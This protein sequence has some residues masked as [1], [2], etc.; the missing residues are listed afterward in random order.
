MLESPPMTE[1]EH[2][3]SLFTDQT[4]TDL[5]LPEPIQ[6]AVDEQGFTHLTRVQ[7]EVLPMSLEGRD[8]VA[9]AQTGS[10]KTAAYLLTIFAHIPPASSRS[11]SRVMPRASA[12]TPASELMSSSGGSTIASNGRFSNVA[13]ISSW[14]RRA[15]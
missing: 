2:S 13:L 12:I 6:R 3:N 14:E 4:F 15:G 7:A 1:S 8:V 10:G 11:K 5:D 9:Q